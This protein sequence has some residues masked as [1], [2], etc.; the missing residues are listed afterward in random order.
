LNDTFCP[1]AGKQTLKSFRPN[2]NYSWS[3]KGIVGVG[4]IYD[5][6]WWKLGKSNIDTLVLTS[7]K[8]QDRKFVYIID[9][10]ITKPD[11]LFFCKEDTTSLISAKGVTTTIAGGIW[12]G[13][14][15]LKK[16]YFNP[17]VTG[18][19]TF[20]IRYSSKGCDDTLI[21]V[22][23]DKPIIQTDTSICLI[24]KPIVLFKKD[25]NGLF[26]GNGIT[27]SSGLFS[28]MT[29]GKGKQIISYRAST[30]CLNSVNIFV[31]TVPIIRFNTPTFYCAKDSLFPLQASPNGGTFTGTG[32]IGN[33]IN[34][35]IA[36]LGNLKFYYAI[37][38]NAC[39]TK[40]SMAFVVNTPL[41]VSVTPQKD[42]VCYG[43]I[44]TL[45][46]SISGGIVANQKISWS[47]GQTGLKTFYIG[48][49]SGNLIITGSDGCSDNVSD[50]AKIVVHPRVWVSATI[51]DTVC[52][53]LDGWA[54]IKLGNGNPFKNTWSHDPNYKKDTLF[55]PADN[56]Y[57]ATIT[58]TKTGCY[59]DTTIEIP[60]YQAIQ[61]GF[62][63]QKSTNTNCLTPL[64]QMATF[65]NQ[66][67]GG[68]RGTWHWG[69][70]KNNLFDPAS[71]PTHTF[72][73]LQ[74]MYHVM[75]SIENEGG[76]K[77]TAWEDVCYHDTIFA[78][79]PNAF[80]P[81]G[82]GINDELD[83]RLYGATESTVYIINRWGEVVFESTDLNTRWNGESAGKPCPE[84]VYAVVVKFKGNHQSKR[85]LSTSV[86]LLRPKS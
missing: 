28:P 60:G 65:F 82:D 55:A 49:K 21:V 66:S 36:R 53:G 57:R 22:V 67:I 77:D 16:L 48:N 62:S 86:T 64:D 35:K 30:G 24:G 1:S 83:C 9:N 26:W 13:P 41:S 14:G 38:I 76:C 52:R 25:K 80:S 39:A 79:L 71:N 23:R 75:L 19:G 40:D 78:F 46:A 34:P 72:D 84:G 32:V 2:A 50:T 51:S 27:N 56:R 54:L 47:H 63:I 42:S 58:D 61:A 5:P 12:S 11:T 43:S 81:N 20:K 70:G 15:I 10:Q 33:N 6:S 73:G 18:P 37:N 69:D 44:V 3:G 29:S 74:T 31:D 4:N 8:C 45:N 7:P 17:Q 85:V 59:G 68:T